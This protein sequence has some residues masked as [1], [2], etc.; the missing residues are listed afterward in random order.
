MGRRKSE[1]IYGRVP[2]EEVKQGEV[3]LNP[4]SVTDLPQ[5]DSAFVCTA[6]SLHQASRQPLPSPYSS[7]LRRKREH[8]MSTLPSTLSL[9]YIPVLLLSISV[10]FLRVRC[11]RICSRSEPRLWAAHNPPAALQP[12]RPLPSRT[13][14][15]FRAPSP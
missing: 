9:S 13:A 15:I 4:P 10:I 7:D 11:L 14:A 8:G 3:E 2:D 5:P 1:Q 6:K 12:A